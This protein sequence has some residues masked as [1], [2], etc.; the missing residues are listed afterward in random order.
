MIYN[1]NNAIFMDDNVLKELVV[2]IDGITIDKTAIQFD[3]IKLSESVCGQGDFNLLSVDTNQLDLTLLSY[4]SAINY[5][6]KEVVIT[7]IGKLGDKTAS[8]PMGIYNVAKV[9]EYNNFGIKLTCYDRMDMFLTDVTTWFDSLVFPITIDNMLVSLCNFVGVPLATTRGEYI[10]KGYTISVKPIEVQG[11]NGKQVL[12]W[13]NEVTASFWKVDRSGV[14]K[15]I[16]VKPRYDS[17]IPK[18]LPFT[19][20]LGD[21]IT[22][23]QDITNRHLVSITKSKISMNK[24]DKVVVRKTDDDIG[25]IVGTGENAYI[26]QANPLLYECTNDGATA[27]LRELSKVAMTP[28]TCKLYCSLPFLECGDYVNVQE[29]NT[30]IFKR[31]IT[32]PF[33]GDMYENNINLERPIVTDVNYE[34]NYLKGKQAEIVKNVDVFKI[35]MKDF[36][37]DTISQLQLTSQELALKVGTGDIISAINVSPETVKIN[38][39][40]LDITGIVTVTDLAT[41]G[42]TTINGANLI[43]GTVQADTVKAGVSLSAPF[44]YGASASFTDTISLNV[45][46]GSTVSMIRLYDSSGSYGYIMGGSSTIGLCARGVMIT[47]DSF[48]WGSSTVATKS[49]FNGLS[50][51]VT[52]KTFDGRNIQ[53]SFTGGLLM[54]TA[55]V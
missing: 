44:I 51:N 32:L 29:S 24:I 39:S 9:E 54:S 15:R 27:I 10:N 30:M 41:A 6:G 5:V 23:V 46:C 43:T 18:L 52:L 40:K 2:T 20:G 8:I 12:A 38:T 25:V 50:N 37:D 48:R 14:L 55:I 26:I 33:S 17:L 42:A 7:L 35:E 3:S 21:E 36:A 31:T 45:D 47:A 19:I 28:F 1:D 16:E 11:L 34:M 53:L 13:I 4:D 22:N 49:D